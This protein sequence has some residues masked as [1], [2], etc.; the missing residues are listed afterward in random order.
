MTEDDTNGPS[1][2]NVMGTCVRDGDEVW[3]EGFEM[4]YE[5]RQGCVLHPLLSTF[6]FLFAAILL[7]A[8]QRFREDVDIFDD[9]AH[10][11]EQPR[12]RLAQKQLWSMCPA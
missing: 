12:L 6:K 2:H 8:L 7:V 9:L 1:I 5:L 4:A 10:L 11:Q 3:T